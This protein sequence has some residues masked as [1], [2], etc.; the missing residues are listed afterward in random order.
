[1]GLACCLLNSNQPDEDCS[2]CGTLSLTGTH[3]AYL[4]QLSFWMV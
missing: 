3:E 2:A 4:V 1:M